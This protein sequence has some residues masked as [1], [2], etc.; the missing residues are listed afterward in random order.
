DVEPLLGTEPRDAKDDDVLGVRAEL[1]P[2]VRP[3]LA[4]PLGPHGEVLDVDSVR[5][6]MHSLRGGTARDHR[7]ARQ[8]AGDEDA[9][10]ALDDRRDDGSLHCSAPAWP[11]ALV[12]ALDDE[13][14]GNP[15]EPTPGDR[16]LCCERAP[17]GD[18]DDIG[19]GLRQ[20]TD[21]AGRDRIL[22][23]DETLGTGAPEAAEGHLSAGARDAP[24]APG[25]GPGRVD[26]RQVELGQ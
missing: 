19:A 13:N 7:V 21:Y 26:D 1:A 12:V 4:K 3:A 16:R 14:V 2:K 15:L 10:R 20:R 9:R 23:T 8:R 5:E 18:D 25:D 11:W 22:V 17:A 24:C 6:Q